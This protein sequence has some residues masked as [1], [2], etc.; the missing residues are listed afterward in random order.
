[1]TEGITLEGLSPNFPEL[2]L[3]GPDYP[4]I[5]F[6]PWRA[7]F[8]F[9]FHHNYHAYLSYHHPLDSRLG[10]CSE[11]AGTWIASSDHCCPY[12]VYHNDEH[13]NGRL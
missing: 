8:P 6:Y 11:V 9:P 5:V 7:L 10:S 13:E 3:D 12:N 1:M 4:P 2:S